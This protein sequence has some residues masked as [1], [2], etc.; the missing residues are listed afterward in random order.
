MSEKIR[1][2][3]EAVRRAREL[4]AEVD[5][6]PFE[7]IEWIDCGVPIRI[8]MSE[9]TDWLCSGRSNSEFVDRVIDG[10]D[11]DFEEPS[12]VPSGGGWPSGGNSRGLFDWVGEM[13][14]AKLFPRGGNARGLF[15][16]A[17]V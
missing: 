6:I 9:A 7:D 16:W 3:A 4:L 10:N 17:G 8:S 1:V 12:E 2:S 14:N 11:D 13:A 5:R 15:D